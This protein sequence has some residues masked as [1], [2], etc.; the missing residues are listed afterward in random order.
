MRK[1]WCG[2]HKTGR[3]ARPYAYFT[4]GKALKG[5]ERFTY[6]WMGA[7]W[8]FASAEHLDM[9]R[10]N[11]EKYAPQYGGY[12]AYRIAMGYIAKGDPTIWKIVDGRLYLNCREEIMKQ[13]EQD[14]RGYIEKANK[15]WPRVLE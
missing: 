13:W 6:Q 11:P 10:S 12:W 1:K 2:K 9:F 14:I 4:Q 8:R 15:N 7:E 5:T 3:L